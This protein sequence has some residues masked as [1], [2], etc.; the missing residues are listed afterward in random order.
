M[1]QQ[2][3]VPDCNDSEN[4]LQ[5]FFRAASGNGVRHRCPAMHFI[6][7]ICTASTRLSAACMRIFVVF[8]GTHE[9]RTFTLTVRV[10]SS[11]LLVP[12]S[13]IDNGRNENFQTDGCRPAREVYAQMCVIRCAFQTLLHQATLMTVVPEHKFVTF[14]TMPEL[15]AF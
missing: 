12:Q 6:L 9:K 14:F 1:S 13:L 11:L 4:H 5:E 15:S 8:N 7:N 2:L 10:R 3:G